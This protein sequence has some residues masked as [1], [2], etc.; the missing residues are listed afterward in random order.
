MNNVFFNVVINKHDL[1][2]LNF[3]FSNTLPRKAYAGRKESR[4]FEQNEEFRHS[5]G[6][7]HRAV[8]GTN[9][10]SFDLEI[11][12]A[13]FSTSKEARG[14]NDLIFIT[15]RKGKSARSYHMSATPYKGEKTHDEREILSLH[16]TSSKIVMSFKNPNGK[17]AKFSIL[18]KDIATG[19]TAGNGPVDILWKDDHRYDTITTEQG[20]IY[21][22]I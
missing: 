4:H 11:S 7:F 21:N 22:E 9:G 2:R 15:L 10:F 5:F 16:R 14:N 19:Q 8:F 3:I 1:N 13:I 17:E 18:K 12:C 20:T 6:R